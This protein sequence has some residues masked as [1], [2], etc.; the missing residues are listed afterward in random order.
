MR[1]PRPSTLVCLSLFELRLG[2][3]N[4]FFDESSCFSE[5]TIWKS[6]ICAGLVAVS[7]LFMLLGIFRVGFGS[8]GE[9]ER[10]G[11]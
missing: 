8:R 7:L 3:A 10:L 4:C 11:F 2:A 1:L 5:I 6:L 9:R